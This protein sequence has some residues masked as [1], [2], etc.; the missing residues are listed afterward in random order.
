LRLYGES[1]LGNF[2]TRLPRISGANFRKP[3]FFAVRKRIWRE[4]GS[5]ALWV[6]GACHHSVGAITLDIGGNDGGKL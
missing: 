2:E 3:E 5:D 4:S 6:G 1:S